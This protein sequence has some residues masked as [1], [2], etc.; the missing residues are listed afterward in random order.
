[1]TKDVSMYEHFDSTAME[2]TKLCHMRLV[3]LGEKSLHR[4][5]QQ[6][7]LKGVNSCK[8]QFYEHYVKGKK[9]RISFVR[10]IGNA[11]GLC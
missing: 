1:M 10:T 3:Y 4:L 11:S 7:L 2:T 8:L 5:N 9:I 6:D